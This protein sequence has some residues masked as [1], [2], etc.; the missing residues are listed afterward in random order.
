MV[1][2]VHV[3]CTGHSGTRSV[4]RRE[5]H[6]RLSRVR[7]RDEIDNQIYLG[8]APA[9]FTCSVFS[10][11][12]VESVTWSLQRRSGARSVVLGVPPGCETRVLVSCESVGS[13]ESVDFSGALGPAVSRYWR[14]RLWATL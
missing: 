14:T 2:P 10:S 4:R 9:F 3:L 12:L 11:A 5:P 7:G 8:D 6:L 1:S 13:A